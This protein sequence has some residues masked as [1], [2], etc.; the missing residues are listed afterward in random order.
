MAG[1]VFSTLISPVSWMASR[2]GVH[3]VRRVFSAEKCTLEHLIPPPEPFTKHLVMAY[4]KTELENKTKHSQCAITSYNYQLNIPGSRPQLK[5]L[6]SAFGI[7][8]P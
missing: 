4:A 7:V 2:G 5:L 6:S 3:L 8:T 1:A